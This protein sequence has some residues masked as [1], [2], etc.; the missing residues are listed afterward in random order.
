[1]D[2]QSVKFLSLLDL[3]GYCDNCPTVATLRTQLSAIEEEVLELRV[4]NAQLKIE[5][6]EMNRLWDEHKSL[7]DEAREKEIR[8]K[9][10]QPSSKGS[11]ADQQKRMA[12]VR[13]KRKKR[14][15]NSVRSQFRSRKPRRSKGG[16]TGHTGYGM[17]LPKDAEKQCVRHYP[18]QCKEC[19]FREGCF[20]SMTRQERRHVVDLQIRVIDTQHETMTGKCP[21]SWERLCGIFPES[22]TSSKQY[23]KNV[24]AYASLL[25]Y[26]G[27]M[28]Y[29]TTTEI[30]NEMGVP[31]STATVYSKLAELAHQPSVQRALNILHQQLIESHTLHADETSLNINASPHWVHAL[32]S[33]TAVHYHVSQQRGVKGMLDGNVLS[34]PV[35]ILVHDCW[36][37]YWHPS[38]SVKRHAVCNAH[39]IRDLDDVT[40]LDPGAHWAALMIDLLLRTNKACKAARARN[41]ASLPRYKQKLIRRRYEELLTLGEARHPRTIGKQGKKRV[42]QPLA[43]RLLARLRKYEDAILLFIEDLQVPFT[44]NLAEQIIRLVVMREKAS[45][46]FAT[47]AGAQ[48]YLAMMSLQ[49]T[50]RR[51]SM[52]AFEAIK[53]CQADRAEEIVLT[54]AA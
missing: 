12:K 42:K 22:V 27:N 45:G 41:K 3:Q 34:N 43:V 2:F 23:G 32:C 29:E 54:P 47:L 30:L 21:V 10:N 33:P 5:N 52:S 50:A 28:S 38:L 4:E 37:S 9:T 39:L 44:N 46:Y 18:G 35:N 6:E 17:S 25:Y 1:M 36:A 20:S 7:L 31:I 51:R 19:A 48:D 53:L 13:E 24:S 14:K 40:T 15:E 49:E 16:Q 26:R 8:Q 11:L